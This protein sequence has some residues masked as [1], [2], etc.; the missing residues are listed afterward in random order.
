MLLTNWL[1]SLKHRRRSRS[2]RRSLRSSVPQIELLENR[3]LLSSV[4]GSI[5]QPESSATNNPP[6]ALFVVNSFADTVDARPGDG[7]AADASGNTTLRAA[8]ME[9]NSLAS[10]SIISLPAGTYILRL[11][12]GSEDSATTGDLDITGNITI[13]GSGAATTT[14]DANGFDRILHV[15]SGATVTIQEV[16]ITGG[17]TT[18]SG[19]GGIR[20]DGG[21]LTIT[22]SS[23]IGNAAPL[24]GGINSVLGDTIITSSTISGNTATV[25]AGIRNHRGTMTVADTTISDNTAISVGGGIENSWGNMIVTNTTICGNTG[26]A[27]GGGIYGGG[28]TIT[29][30]TISGN[31]SWVG[32][33]IFAGGGVSISNSTMTANTATYY[34]GGI[35][36]D[37]PYVALTLDNTIL[38]GNT[39]GTGPDAYSPHGDIKSR[40]HNLIG[41]NDFNFTPEA[42]DL[43]GSP[44]T[45]ID[46]LIGPLQDHGG[47]TVTHALLPGSPAIDA[48]ENVGIPLTDQRGVAR[49]QDGN[50]DGLAVTDIG[51]FEVVVNDVA[52]QLGRVTSVHFADFMD[53][54]GLT[55]NGDALQS[56]NVLRLTPPDGPRAGSVFFTQPVRVDADTS[57][58]A[59]FQFCISESGGLSGGADGIVFIVQ[60]SAAGT[61]A[62]GDP[63]G[64][65]GYDASHQ[66]DQ[67]ITSSLGIEF[68]TYNNGSSYG[69]PNNNHVALLTNGA[70]R[71]PLAVATPTFDLNSGA[72]LNVWIDYDGTA[73]VLQVFMGDTATKPAEPLLTQSDIDLAAL[74]GS[75][76]FFGFSGATWAGWGA[77]DIE[78][79]ELTVTAG[80]ELQL[81]ATTI[82]E[83]DT[84]RLMGT[85]SDVGTLDT[86]ELTIDWGDGSDG[87]VETVAVAGGS[88]DIPH[89]YLDDNPTGTMSDEY[90]IRVTLPDVESGAITDTI[91]VTVLNVAPTVDAG[92]DT[93]L[94]EDAELSS[95]SVS[96]SDPGS[97][98]W[99]AT[100]DY[101]DGT[102]VRQ[103][104]AVSER[105][106]TLPEH[107]YADNGSYTVTVTVADDDGATGSDTFVVT[108]RDFDSGSP[109]SVR[110]ALPEGGGVFELL[111][112]GTDLMV[113]QQ[114]GE[115]L[116]RVPT[117]LAQTL[118]IDGSSGDDTVIVNLSADDFIPRD[119]VTVKGGPGNDVLVLADGAAIGAGVYDGGAGID[120]VDYS[121]FLRGVSVNLRTGNATGTGGISNVTSIIGGTGDDTLMG[122]ANANGLWGGAGNDVLRGGRGRDSLYGGAGNDRLSGGAGNDVLRG[123]RGRDSLHGGRGNDRLSGGAG[124]DMLKGGRGRDSLHGGAGKD[125][126]SGGAGDDVLKGGRGSDSLRGGVG[127]DRLFGGPG[128]DALRGGRGRDNLRG[129]AGKDRLSGGAG[130][131]VLKGGWGDDSLRGGAGDDR[132]FGGPGD[133]VLR[134]SWGDDSLRG[135]AGDDRLFGGPGD[136]VLRGGRGDDSLHGGVGDDRLFGGPGDDVLRGGWGDDSLHDGAGDDPLSDGGGGGYF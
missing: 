30:S 87:G 33:G 85:Y 17:N 24:G 35:H 57:F 133:D 94:N 72:A 29:N 122:D 125:R 70:I 13:R 76:A 71:A 89:Q 92:A 116:Y 65:L 109:P 117:H 104:S 120:T 6:P 11:P 51:A 78:N 27:S 5:L 73:D 21:M 58:G 18:V 54:S 82:N 96:F 19:G 36:L 100:V 102:G 40:G 16:M 110:V 34:G 31:T 1:R 67:Q 61:D 113:R 43:V 114:Q 55:L 124:N 74:V 50:K 131:A 69:D 135:G 32:G 46:P 64:D 121:A 60:N 95:H 49:P 79:W 53:I 106:L 136:D 14:I 44:G 128:D 90:T 59:R 107:S 10:E 123:G 45:P 127:D 42:T 7:L 81:S 39:A 20:N 83:N 98:T 108:V 93:I 132:L 26:R 41:N 48:G 2:R 111:V 99:S 88:F 129:G 28:M 38:A 103:L 56:G 112:E 9:C 84:V 4:T 25:G 119:G 12:G 134:G 130:D 118:T 8:I 86:H 97:D 47:P 105:S 77:H 3:M 115:E 37:Y 126:L 22:D 75:Q 66:P 63:G 23:I 80:T 68:D 62:L 101:G 52:P 15:L 91:K